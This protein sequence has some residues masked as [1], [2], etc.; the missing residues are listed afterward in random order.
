MIRRALWRRQALS[1]TCA[2]SLATL[3][4]SGC[5][6]TRQAV[7]M[8]APLRSGYNICRAELSDTQKAELRAALASGQR[9]AFYSA[10]CHLDQ[11]LASQIYSPLELGPGEPPPALPVAQLIP[12]QQR[13]DFDR[14]NLERPSGEGEIL[15]YLLPASEEE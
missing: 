3:L 14:L 2:L 7:T 9:L 13:R 10:G 4:L 8:R 11:R 15:L 1:S 5:V 6:M 12:L